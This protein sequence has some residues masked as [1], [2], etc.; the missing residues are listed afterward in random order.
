MRKEARLADMRIRN[1]GRR[2]NEPQFDTTLD[3][4]K[5]LASFMML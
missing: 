2:Q 3:G 1:Q 5:S 4:R